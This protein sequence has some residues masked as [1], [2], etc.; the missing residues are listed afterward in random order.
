M[1]TQLA[2]ASK[3][4]S[5]TLMA[6]MLVACLVKRSDHKM[7]SRVSTRSCCIHSIYEFVYEWNYS[8]VAALDSQKAQLAIE[9]ALVT[10]FCGYEEPTISAHRHSNRTDQT[11]V[12][13]SW[14]YM[15]GVLLGFQ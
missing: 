7:A 15:L 1:V 4:D 8:L 12:V 9:S 5:V 3:P 11:L 13:K 6:S 14:D 10:A 2:Q